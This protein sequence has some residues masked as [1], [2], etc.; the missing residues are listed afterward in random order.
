MSCDGSGDEVTDTATFA[1][2]PEIGGGRPAHSQSAVVR[3]AASR[4]IAVVLLR[5]ASLLALVCSSGLIV[6][7]SIPWARWHRASPSECDAG[8][9]PHHV[10]RRSCV[11]PCRPPSPA[12]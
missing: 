5:L 3:P 9:R 6:R 4:M 12:G 7:F 8:P 10:S 11:H 2:R 1:E